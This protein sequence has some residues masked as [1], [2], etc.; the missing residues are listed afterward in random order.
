MDDMLKKIALTGIV[1][2]VIIASP[3]LRSEPQNE[4]YYS[5]EIDDAVAHAKRNPV[6]KRYVGSSWYNRS[7][8]NS[9]ALPKLLN[10]EMDNQVIEG[11]V[12]AT[13]AGDNRNA[14][15]EEPVIEANLGHTIVS[16][17]VEETSLVRNSPT[18]ST[19]QKVEQSQTSHYTREI[20]YDSSGFTGSSREIR[21]DV[22]ITAKIRP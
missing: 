18:S 17:N 10:K 2:G 8:S 21:S 14:A 19:P 22:T 13:A 20:R 16:D 15:V 4:D 11:A 6:D 5:T 12:G 3:F 9:F 7:T 1:G